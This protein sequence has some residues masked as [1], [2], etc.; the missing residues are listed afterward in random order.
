MYGGWAET[1]IKPWNRE[2]HWIHEPLFLPGKLTLLPLQHELCLLSSMVGSKISQ[3]HRENEG[4]HIT[5][6]YRSWPQFVIV[7][8]HTT[9]NIRQGEVQGCAGLFHLT[10]QQEENESDCLHI[11]RYC[12]IAAILENSYH[13]WHE[14]NMD[15]LWS[16]QYCLLCLVWTCKV[17]CLHHWS[18][19]Y[20]LATG[21]AI[22]LSHLNQVSM[23]P[24]NN[25]SNAWASL[26]L[27]GRNVA[28]FQNL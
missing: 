5:H 19:L 16:L 20:H 24:T 9:W 3:H 10:G 4:L 26:Y 14:D 28:T 25:G 23:Q 22:R 11:G 2:H 17:S 21:L 15:C 13:G 8:G 18:K 27:I 1:E 7:F 6:N 12:S